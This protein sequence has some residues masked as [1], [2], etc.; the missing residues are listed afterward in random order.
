MLYGLRVVMNGLPLNDEV[1]YGHIDHLGYLVH[2]SELDT[3]HIPE[4]P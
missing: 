3:V 2:I 1:V 4:Q